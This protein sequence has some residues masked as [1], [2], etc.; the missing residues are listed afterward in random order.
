MDKEKFLKLA[1]EKHGDKYDYKLVEIKG[2][3]K[4][5]IICK[6][7][8][9]FEQR[10]DHH[11]TGSGC[12]KCMGR[13][14]T[15]AEFIKELQLKHGDKYDYSETIYTK[16][17]HK[18]KVKCNKH[19]IFEVMARDHLHSGNGCARCTGRG[20]TTEEFIEQASKIHND[21]YD[22][23]LVEYKRSAD[24]I[25][26][27]CKTH[28]IFEQKAQEHL[29]GYGCAKC[30][31]KGKTVEEFINE[32]NKIHNNKYS[33]DLVEF[34]FITE[35]VQIECDKHGL[36]EQK[37]SSHMKGAGCTK[38]VHDQAAIK[39]KSTK[40]EFIKKAQLRH[41]DL[42]NYDLVEYV[43]SKTKV[44]I[45]CE[46]HGI[47]EQT[48][49]DHYSSGCFKCNGTIT[50]TTEEFI[51]NANEKHN[52]LYD[53]SLVNYI[54]N[55]T[56]VKILCKD[57]GIFEQTPTAHIEKGTKCPKCYGRNKTLEEFIQLA[58]EKHGDLYDYSTT[59]YKI[60]HGKIKI[61]CNKHGEFIIQARR[62]IE[63]Q[64]CKKCNGKG[65][66]KISIEWLK[67]LEKKNNI[68]IIHA[69][70]GNEHSIKSPNKGLY[71]ADGYCEETNTWYEFFGDLYHFSPKKFKEDDVNFLHRKAKDVWEYDK[72]RK[73]FIISKGY[74]YIS[75]WENEWI[76]IRKTI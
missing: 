12:S 6:T 10:F 69:E 71:R 18:I 1:V 36:F 37:A 7:H 75:I 49:S 35:K 32:S 5:K 66:S 74:N 11:L 51:K 39:Y 53:Y 55:R 26:I 52:N 8:D 25:K 63:G 64:G 16:L 38:C 43:N 65:Y 34:T 31:G 41:G 72:K 46:D 48:P 44:K 29:Y 19:G 13:N 20:K 50:K 47:F 62:H 17:A 54:N 15:T 9:I 56:K 27:I 40:E 45:I 61:K 3:Q 28:G 4:I 58:K 2:K 21:K 57:H 33:Y 76:E 60:S 30:I 14:K 68:K 59:E 23:S 70:N 67:Y 42:Y 24:I 73:E 22:Y